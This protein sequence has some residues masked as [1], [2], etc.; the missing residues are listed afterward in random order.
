MPAGLGL[1]TLPVAWGAPRLRA[2]EVLKS[3][4]VRREGFEP[5]TRCLEGSRSVP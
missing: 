4:L 5:P 2:V 1:Q 3:V